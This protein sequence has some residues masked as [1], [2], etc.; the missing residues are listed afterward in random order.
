MANYVLMCV[1]KTGTSTDEM[2]GVFDSVQW[3]SPG[4]NATMPVPAVAPLAGLQSGDKVSFAV[5]VQDATGAVQNGQLDWVSV[6]VSAVTAPGN[7]NTRFADNSSPFRIGSGSRSNTM[8]L[9]SKSG[10]P[11]GMSDYA[12][13]GT[14]LPPGSTGAFRGLGMLQIYS[15]VPQGKTAPN[16][17]SSQYEAVIG[18]SVTAADG[19]LWQF[20]FDPEMDVNNGN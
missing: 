20:T 19:S 5:Q 9:A 16:R 12:A 11:G 4:N 14:L 7:R 6:S 1:A 13:D 2:D 17:A 18:C 8:L 3:V 15:D 10:S